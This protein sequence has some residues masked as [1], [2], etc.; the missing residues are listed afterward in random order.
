MNR[1]DEAK[2]VGTAAVTQKKDTVA[3][4]SFFMLLAAAKHDEAEMNRHLV[5]SNGKPFDAIL[6]SRL[7]AYQDSVGRVKLA[8][9]TLQQADAAAQ[10]AGLAEFA[11]NQMS[12]MAA[13]DAF[14]GFTNSARQKAAQSARLSSERL[15]VGYAAIALAQIG[16]SAQAEKLINELNRE[17]PADTSLQNCSLPGTRAL[18]LLHKN[19]AAQAVSMLE[20]LRKY[21]LGFPATNVAYFILFVR[22]RAY[23]QL[24][25]GA[26]AAGEFQTILD[27]SGVNPLSV[28]LPLAQLNLARAYV[29]QGETAKAKTAYQDFFASWKDADADVPV[30]IAAKAEYAKLQ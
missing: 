11:A 26:D 1:F 2:A 17:Y 13:R 28:F 22:G 3:I 8:R 16:D 14:H 29:L 19:G 5:W 24:K 18:L 12:I 4:H 27:H 25:D 23:L 9:E 21:D 30:L 10:K 15:V 7:V 6:R 20:P